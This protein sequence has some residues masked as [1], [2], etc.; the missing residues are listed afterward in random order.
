MRSY[1]FYQ[2]ARLRVAHYTDDGVRTA[3]GRP[4]PPESR[5]TN[6]TLGRCKNCRKALTLP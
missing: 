1:W 4:V 3:C 2:N 6:V 5:T